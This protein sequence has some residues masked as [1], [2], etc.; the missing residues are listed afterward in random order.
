MKIILD[1]NINRIYVQ[2]LCMAFFHGI[3][4]PDNFDESTDGLEL[5]LKLDEKEEFL[6]VISK[7]SW[8]NKEAK[9]EE[10]YE[11]SSNETVERARK[12]AVG[13]A[14][15]K[16]CKQLTEK[17]VDWGILTGIR[18]SKVCLELLKTKS[19]NE[20]LVELCD[21]YLLSEAKAKLLVKVTQNE[22]LVMNKTDDLSCSLYIS[23]PFCPSRC[24]YCS[25]ISCAGEKM[26]KLIPKYLEKLTLEI[27][28][29]TELIKNM[30]FR[31]SCVYIGGGT[32]TVLNEEQLELLLKEVNVCVNVSSLDEF[33]LEAGRPDTITEE[34]LVLAKK[35]GVTR[36]S[37][38]PQ[39]LNDSVLEKIG[40]HHTSQDFLI[41][42]DKVEKSQ[43][44][45]I[46]TDLIAGLEDDDFNSFKKTVDK[47]VALSPQNVTVHSFC[48]KKSARILRDDAEIY[49]QDDIDAKKS[50]DY[51]IDTLLGNGYEPYY[52]YRQKNTVGNLENVGYSKSGFFGLYNVFMMSDAHTVFGVGAGATTKLVKNNNGKTDILRIFSPKYPYEYLQD[53]QNNNGKITE[54]FNRR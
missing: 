52:M 17:D 10:N 18:P 13:Q 29:T 53:N 11:L 24:N 45:C 20:V 36:I 21:K 2:S 43:I 15:Y 6:S 30:G 16:L 3:K 1:G 38:N 9:I 31:L 35:Y 5:Y 41:S 4:F 25:F 49:N 23:I 48:V 47:I 46:N 28:N 14:V 40:R 27:K 50:V 44:D 32:P 51:A 19:E 8:Y 39:T 37:V 34:K 22:H 54:F 7:L 12:T 33:T 42:F 26:L